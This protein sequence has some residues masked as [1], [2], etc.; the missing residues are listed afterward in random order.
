MGN[1][2]RNDLRSKR[3]HENALIQAL[4]AYMGSVVRG[5][6]YYAKDGSILDV[7]RTYNDRLE[8]ILK[9]HYLNVANPFAYRTQR[10]LPKEISI[11]NSEKK[12][13]SRAI[14]H[15]SKIRAALISSAINKNLQ[16]TISVSERQVAE[17]DSE[18]QE[19]SNGFIVNKASIV[20]FQI[21][22]TT[23]HLLRRKFK[24]MMPTIATTETQVTAETYKLTEA[25][26]LTGIL[27]SVLGGSSNP[28]SK[29]V[30][31]T[32]VS[33]FDERLRDSHAEADSQTVEQD[34]PFS[35]N[36]FSLMIPSD[37]SLGAPPEE[38]IN[39]RCAAV[40]DSGEIIAVRYD[41]ETEE[42]F[43]GMFQ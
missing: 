38:T 11:T 10:V 32:W 39:C 30:H 36:G 35:V 6:L 18:T 24:N 34:K 37:S 31:K 26:V 19:V 16:K 12:V 7:Q 3:K 43:I 4:S 8:R 17:M 27:P 33:I 20:G 23:A 42:N 14:D 41:Q 28:I 9:N 1:A 29:K 21:S 22:L 13:L 25:Q 15:Y 2:A 5:Y 40:F